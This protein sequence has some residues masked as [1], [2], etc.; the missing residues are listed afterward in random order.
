MGRFVY[1]HLFIDRCGRGIPT[2]FFSIL[3][4]YIVENIW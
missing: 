3:F 2:F 1:T 4:M